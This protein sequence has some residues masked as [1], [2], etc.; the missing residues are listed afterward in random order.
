M[1]SMGGGQLAGAGGALLGGDV[2][3]VYEVYARPFVAA[4]DTASVARR[5]RNVSLRGSGEL[6]CIAAERTVADVPPPSTARPIPLA[7]YLAMQA[8]SCT[9]PS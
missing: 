3:Q 2:R 4:D 9:N 7:V 5:E 6:G 1:L 8:L